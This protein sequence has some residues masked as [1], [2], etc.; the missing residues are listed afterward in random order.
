[1]EDGTED[2]HSGSEYEE[3][4]DAHRMLVRLEIRNAQHQTSESQNRSLGVFW[5][6]LGQSCGTQRHTHIYAG[7]HSVS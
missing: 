7:W 3:L 4:I 2:L 1:M 5:R 6:K